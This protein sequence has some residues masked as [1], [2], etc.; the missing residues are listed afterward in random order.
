VRVT[1]LGS[2]GKAK[3]ELWN[4]NVLM[5]PLGGDVLNIGSAFNFA[6]K[7]IYMSNNGLGTACLPAYAYSRIAWQ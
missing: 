5:S 1:A 4:N 2:S 7:N 3:L 6:S